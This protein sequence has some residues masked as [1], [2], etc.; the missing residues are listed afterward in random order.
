VTSQ[1]RLQTHGWTKSRSHVLLIG[2]LI[3]ILDEANKLAG[4]PL[5]YTQLHN[6]AVSAAAMQSLQVEWMAWQK[7]KQGLWQYGV[8]TALPQSLCQLPFL[9]VPECKKVIM[10]GEAMLM[11]NHEVQNSLERALAIMQQGAVRHPFTAALLLVER[12]SQ[13]DDHQVFGNTC[14]K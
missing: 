8:G 11:Q 10:Q 2:S 9:M 5:P 1:P 12:T 4:N 3:G 6:A 13:P 7:V 14:W